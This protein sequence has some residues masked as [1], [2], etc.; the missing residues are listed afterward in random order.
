MTMRGQAH[1]GCSRGVQ[2]A[3]N[4]ICSRCRKEIAD[5]ANYCSACGERQAAAGSA[6]R[7]GRR[8]L[9]RSAAD[10]KIAGVCG[11]VAEYLGTDPTLVRLLWAVLTVVPGCLVGG[12][13]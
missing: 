11:G 1:E 12:V 5:D 6:G 9:T 8:R 10:V 3:P 4:M 2:G 13:L 7:S